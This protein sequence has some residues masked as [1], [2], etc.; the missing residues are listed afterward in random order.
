M[1][2]PIYQYRT[3]LDGRWIGAGGGAFETVNPAEPEK[4]VGRYGASSE[5]EVASV[6][7]AARRA[8]ADWAAMAG[9]ERHAILQRY[10]AKL[11]ESAEALAQAITREMGKPIVEARGE[12]GYSLIEADFMLGEAARAQGWLMPSFRR[13][14]QNTVVRRPRGVVAAISPWNYPFLTPMRKVAPA[15]VFGNAVVLKPSEFSPAA[16]CMA[17]ELAVGILPEG[18]FGI[19][20]GGAK[21][22]RALVA[23][24][25][26]DAVTFTGSV[27]TGRAIYQIAAGHLAEVSLELGGKNP[28]VLHDTS[29][30]GACLDEIVRGAMNNGGQRCTAVSRVLVREPLAR[31]VE[32]GLAERF[33]RLVVGNGLDEKTQVG[34]MAM[35]S[36]RDKVLSMIEKGRGESARVATGGE[37]AS[38][39]GFERGYF[40]KPTLLAGVTPSMSV[41]KQE[42]FGPV[43]SMLEYDDIDSALAMANDVEY[44]LA[45]SL[46]S[47]D[48]RVVQRFTQGAEAGMVHVNHQTVVD[49]NMPFIGVK[50]SGVGACSVGQSAASFYTS[51]RSIYI[52]Y[53]LARK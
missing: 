15:L 18:L 20:M 39:P 46:F 34:P 23:D 12:V 2:D 47:E 14:V 3:L 4:V 51:E 5:E 49:P 26:V 42:I 37:A 30:L 9:L 41:A 7:R 27:S 16:A 43:L 29:D 6:V 50:H 8:Q 40:V 35:K 36:H 32:A 52:K 28:V 21:V 11:K 44:G 17:A 24:P 19:V 53:G 25:D 38:P 45:A 33:A 22:G 10:F 13:D 48:P 1:S 31:E